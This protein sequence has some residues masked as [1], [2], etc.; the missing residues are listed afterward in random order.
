LAESELACQARAN[1]RDRCVRGDA[2]PADGWIAALGGG[3]SIG[4]DEMT[5]RSCE[6]R[7]RKPERHLPAIAFPGGSD[8]GV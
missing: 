7:P 3:K 2:A 1:R 4:S 6:D 8:A 5:L